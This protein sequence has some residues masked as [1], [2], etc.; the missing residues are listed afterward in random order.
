MKL[1]QLVALMNTAGLTAAVTFP[2]LLSS[3]ALAGGTGKQEA[4]LHVSGGI[5]MPSAATSV[6]TNPAALV[7][8]KQVLLDLQAGAADIWDHSIYRAGLRTGNG[9]F[10]AAG[11]VENRPGS[12]NSSNQLS[13]YY[14]LAVGTQSFS[15]GVAGQTGISSGGSQF[16]AGLLFQP[17]Q[18][19]NLGFTARGL[20]SGPHEYGLGLAYDFASGVAFILD[21]AADRHLKDI[22][23]KPGL[24]VGNSDAALTLS[25]GTG[26][27]EEFS[28]GVS[29]GAVI[30]F[31]SSSSL[32]LYYNP[33]NDLAHYYLAL[34][35][36]F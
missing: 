23:F 30:H 27:R 36:G 33:G 32:E 20:D 14:G 16:N 6:F 21:S 12:T 15:F 22:Q 25:Y 5:A 9:S 35:L 3:L 8:S 7:S 18:A 29:I 34:A 2:L 4:D 26:D 28:D 11:G 31:K 24:K 1:T 19:L 17:T 10:A 13:A